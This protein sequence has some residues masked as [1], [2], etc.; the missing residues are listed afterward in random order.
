MRGTN[1]HGKTHI[2]TQTERERDVGPKAHS[3]AALGKVPHE[4]LRVKAAAAEERSLRGNGQHL[5]SEDLQ[6]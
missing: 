2:H 1:S 5:Q 6:P 4:Y 3:R